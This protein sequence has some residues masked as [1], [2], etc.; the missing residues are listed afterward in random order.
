VKVK[1]ALLEILHGTTPTPSWLWAH[2]W[3]IPPTCTQCGCQDNIDHMA[4]G[5]AP[6]VNVRKLICKALTRI[7]IPEKHNLRP[8]VMYY[9]NGFP[10]DKADF[11]FQHTEPIFTDGSAKNIQWP[12]IAV[13]SSACIQ[14][15]SDKVQ[16]WISAQVPSTFPISAVSSEFYAFALAAD[17]LPLAGPVPPHCF[18]LPSRGAG[19]R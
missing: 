3:K 6:Q 12:D 8:D 9:I 4:N 17:S 10:V 14:I 1:T 16:R 19:F 2:G 11:R 7:P 5:C 18:G 15:G 13:A